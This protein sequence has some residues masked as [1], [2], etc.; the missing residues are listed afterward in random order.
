MFQFCFQ[1]MNV[2]FS[3]FP[4]IHFL[5]YGT[6]HLQFH[7]M[8]YSVQNNTALK[9]SRLSSISLIFGFI[10]LL[11]SIFNK[12]WYVNPNTSLWLCL[13]HKKVIDVTHNVCRTNWICRMNQHC[14][15]IKR[16]TF[17]LKSSQS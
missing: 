2:F 4:K 8:N 14:W 5:I 15:E 7:Q 11:I 13:I 6:P 17:L 12:M 10:L 1:R 9:F 16:Y 3:H